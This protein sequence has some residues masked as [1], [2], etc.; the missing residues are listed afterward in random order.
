MRSCQCTASSTR[1][2]WEALRERCPGARSRCEE[3]Q[4]QSAALLRP[5]SS[6]RRRVSITAAG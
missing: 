4:R 1:D 6:H 2:G 3:G 5:K